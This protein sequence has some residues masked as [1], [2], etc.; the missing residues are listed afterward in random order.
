MLNNCLI[1]LYQDFKVLKL[2]G[3]ALHEGVHVIRI[4]RMLHSIIF[5]I[6]RKIKVLIVWI[7]G[8]I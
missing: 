2:K 6:Q 4:E 5:P 1:G 3:V 7:T 8:G